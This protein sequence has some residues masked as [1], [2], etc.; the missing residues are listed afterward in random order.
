MINIHVDIYLYII[1]RYKITY[2]LLHNT[3]C[4]TC[5]NTCNIIILLFFSDAEEEKM[6][7][8]PCLIS[9][10]SQSCRVDTQEML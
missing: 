10:C 8:K 5:V 9:K 2:I 7:K 6:S 3:Y 4:I 1:F